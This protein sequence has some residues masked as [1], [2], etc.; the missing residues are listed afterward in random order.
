MPGRRASYVRARNTE[1]AVGQMLVTKF[2]FDLSRC[3]RISMLIETYVRIAWTI[4]IRSQT[5]DSVVMDSNAR[6]QRSAVNVRWCVIYKSM[7]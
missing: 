5:A 7:S 2:L 1:L 3:T 4:R 6:K